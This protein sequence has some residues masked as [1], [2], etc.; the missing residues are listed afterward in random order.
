MEGDIIKP[1]NSGATSTKLDEDWND[2]P[3]SALQAAARR[4]NFG[5]MKHGRFNWKKGDEEFAEVRLSHMLRHAHLFAE[6]K[7]IEDLDALLCNAMML[8]W[9]VDKGILR[10]KDESDK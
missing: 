9:Y 3:F 10:L 2:L 5:R 4:F 6:E 8:A 1:G 7:H